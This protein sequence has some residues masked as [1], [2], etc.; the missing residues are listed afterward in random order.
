MVSVNKKRPVNLDLTTIKLP[1]MAIAS[2][3]HRMSGIIL[4][5]LFP[6]ALC[7]LHCSLESQVSFSNMQLLLSKPL[8]KF[9]LWVFLSALCYHIL[10][11]IRHLIMDIGIG[12]HLEQGRFTARLV[13]AMAFILFILLGIWLW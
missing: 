11:G 12:E 10:A 9:I 4:F 13:V 3:L 2:I 1:I 8:Y 6:L 5:L 7:L